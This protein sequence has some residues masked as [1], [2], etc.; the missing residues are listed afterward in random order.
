MHGKV[1]TKK[2]ETQNEFSWNLEVCVRRPQHWFVSW[3]WMDQVFGSSISLKAKLFWCFVIKVKLGFQS[4]S[5]VGLWIFIGIFLVMSLCFPKVGYKLCSNVCQ[6]H[7]SI[8][9][10]MIH[11]VVHTLDVKHRCKPWFANKGVYCVVVSNIRHGQ[12]V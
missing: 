7:G 11:N 6:P 2:H 8:F 4:W 3:W 12:K 10:Y 1:P 9:S 5:L